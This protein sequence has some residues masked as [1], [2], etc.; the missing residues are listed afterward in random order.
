[1]K[2]VKLMKEIV[3]LQKKL[4]KFKDYPDLLSKINENKQLRMEAETY[5][6]NEKFLNKLIKRL[7]PNGEKVAKV[8]QEL[9]SEGN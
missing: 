8:M 7:E 9:Q 5:R 4:N 3:K 1:M 6:Q 2:K